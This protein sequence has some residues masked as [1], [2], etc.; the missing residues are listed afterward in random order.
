MLEYHGWITLRDSPGEGD[1]RRTDELAHEIEQSVARIH[2]E[3]RELGMRAMNGDH[4]I[5]MAG[6][7]NRWTADMEEILGL[8]REVAEKAPGS[9]GLL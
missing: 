5:W 8:F 6:F 7:R 1:E 2:A 9:Y 3:F 4:T